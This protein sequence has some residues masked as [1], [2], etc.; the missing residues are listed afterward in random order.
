MVEILRVHLADFL[1][2]KENDETK[3]VFY[4]STGKLGGKFM[5]DVKNKNKKKFVRGI[6]WFYQNSCV[7]YSYAECMQNYANFL[8]N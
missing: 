3:S 2:G 4:N 6:C 1:V 8:T 7:G 5:G